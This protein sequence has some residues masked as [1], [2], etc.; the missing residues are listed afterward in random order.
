M[1]E[2]STRPVRAI[3]L[4]AA[5]LCAVLIPALTRPAPCATQE[6]I[7]ARPLSLDDCIRIALQRNPQVTSSQ[8][9]VISAG[10]ALT[11]ARSSY[12]PQLSLAA[13]EGL[14]S[15]TSFLSL[16]GGTFGFGGSDTREDLDLT[17]RLTLWRRGR[18]E[19]VGESR[20]SVRSAEESHASTIQGLVE[21]V[22]SNY[23]A[24]LASQ[25]LLGVAEGGVESAQGHLDQVKARVAL[26]ASADVDAFPAEDDLARA[27]LDL[28]DARSNLQLA[29]AQL[30]NTL[31]IPQGTSVELAEPAAP[32]QQPFPALQEAVKTALETRPEVLAARA[33][34]RASRFALA[35][36]RIRRGP[37][38]DVSGQ[39]DQGYT[40]WQSRNPSWNLLLTLSWPLLDGHATQSDVTAARASV[41]R[42]DANLQSLANQVGLETENALVEVQRTRE[43]VQGTAKSVAAAD[44]RL[45]AAEGKYRQGVGILLE[46]IDARVAVT[47]ARANQVRAR[48]DHQIALVGLQRAMGTLAPPPAQPSAPQ[49]GAS[50]D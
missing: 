34:A 42:T 49:A 29:G 39:Y 47:T 30:T 40:K 46:V 19:S 8:Q 43:R 23:Y 20:A 44:A 2:Q 41:A 35:Q 21:Q 27:Q 33:S 38:M 6:A 14:T 32:Q 3:I 11:R 31:G 5:V 26:G 7:P 1:N 9:G 22:A 12:Y 28:I 17:A 18:R 10:A 48:Y 50:N 4:R 24:V 36:T 15:T 37:A 16:G 25:E 45:A 13:V